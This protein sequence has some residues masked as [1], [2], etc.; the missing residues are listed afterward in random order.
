MV[1]IERPL[2]IVQ[3]FATTLGSQC[4][5]VKSR[6]ISLT[7]CDKFEYVDKMGEVVGKGIIFCHFR[8]PLD[9]CMTPKQAFESVQ[10]KFKKKMRKWGYILLPFHNRIRV[11]EIHS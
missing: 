3:L 10:Q 5:V 9:F 1:T 7:T 6:L 8:A 11:V 2:E 4:N